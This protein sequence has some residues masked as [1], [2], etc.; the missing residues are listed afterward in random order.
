[1]SS[2]FLLVHGKGDAPDCPTSAMI[3]VEEYLKDLNQ[4][5]VFKEYAWGQSREY[6]INV[7]NAV[8]EVIND[9]K[10]L[11]KS[12]TNVLCVGHSLGGNILLQVV[13]KHTIP[14]GIVLINPAGNVGVAAFG[15]H[16]SVS[17]DKAKSM[18]S[19]NILTKEEF[20]DLNQGERCTI[21]CSPQNYID[22]FSS[23]SSCNMFNHK[24]DEFKDQVILLITSV[25]DVSQRQINYIWDIIKS[26][27]KSKRMTLPTSEHFPEEAHLTRMYK[28][29][30]QKIKL[31]ET[32]DD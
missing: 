17:L 20:V 22:W 29:F 5:V 21:R 15:I 9:I 12:Y 6:D 3:G 10:E 16:C 2:V 1:M 28:W 13:K 32:Q 4:N 7:N 24:A 18:V 23:D 27:P 30:D 14:E 31:Q 11:R 8:D 19:N 25:G 26:N